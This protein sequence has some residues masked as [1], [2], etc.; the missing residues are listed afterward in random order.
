MGSGRNKVKTNDIEVLGASLRGA[1]IENHGPR[2]GIEMQEEEEKIMLFYHDWWEKIYLQSERYLLRTKEVFEQKLECEK[3]ILRTMGAFPTKWK[4]LEAK[5][6][7]EEFSGEEKNLN[8][9]STK[10]IRHPPLCAKSNIFR[11]FFKN[12]L[13]S[14]Q[15][16]A[17]NSKPWESG[18]G[19]L[20]QLDL[21]LPQMVSWSQ[22]NT[23]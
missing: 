2:L 9:K 6:N 18:N 16:Q 12:M 1:Q 19:H 3:V 11:A 23:C 7:A 15:W 10:A 21:W 20:H 22:F 14:S 17:S 4:C 5:D 8:D 13:R